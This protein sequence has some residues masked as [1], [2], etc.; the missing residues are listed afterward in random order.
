MLKFPQSHKYKILNSFN[1]Q[2]D[3]NLFWQVSDFYR[4]Q[5]LWKDSRPHFYIDEQTCIFSSWYDE[6]N[7]KSILKK[8]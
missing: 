1:K 5:R 7:V 8:T 4:W 3:K 2:I 6:E